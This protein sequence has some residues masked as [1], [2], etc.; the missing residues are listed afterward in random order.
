MHRLHWMNP[1]DLVEEYLH[2]TRFLWRCEQNHSMSFQLWISLVRNKQPLL[3]HMVFMMS[4]SKSLWRH[5]QRFFEES[6]NLVSDWWG[7]RTGHGEKISIIAAYART[8]P[9]HFALSRRQQTYLSFHRE[10]KCICDVIIGISWYFRYSV[11]FES[12]CW[13]RSKIKWWETQIK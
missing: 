13:W 2:R 4:Q 8:W 6:S 5:V 9:R 3:F 10:N 1:N 7:V 12:R 11:Y